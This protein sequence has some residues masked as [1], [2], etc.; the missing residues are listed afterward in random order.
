MHSDLFEQRGLRISLETKISN[1]LDCH[2]L[3]EKSIR[4]FVI[5]RHLL[6]HPESFYNFTNDISY[7]HNSILTR[8]TCWRNKLRVSHN[9]SQNGCCSVKKIL[10]IIGDNK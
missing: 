6:K 8:C 10:F 4:A 1:E 3:V 2:C 5:V 7:E 9:T